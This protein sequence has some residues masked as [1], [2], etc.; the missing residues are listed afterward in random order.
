MVEVRRCDRQDQVLDLLRVQRRVHDCHRA[1]LADRHDVELIKPVLFQDEIHG[2]GDVS[3]DVIV[4]VKKPVLAGRVPPVEHVDV[5]AGVEEGFHD[6]AARLQVEHRLPVHLGVDDEKRCL[7]QRLRP[8]VV[9]LE[10]DAVL[11]PDDVVGGDGDIRLQRTQ[12]DLF[13]LPDLVVELGRVAGHP[14][15]DQIGRHDVGSHHFGKMG[16][17]L[18]LHFASPS[19]RAL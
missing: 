16:F 2:I 18:T 3:V 1:A 10:L 11:L 15:H 4:E 9:V 6:T 5:E 14:G 19:S 13:G 8:G 7:E 17:F 12:E